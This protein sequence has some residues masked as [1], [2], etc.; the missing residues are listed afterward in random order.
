MVHWSRVLRFNGQSLPYFAWQANG[1]W[2]DS[3]LQHVRDALMNNDQTTQS[4]ATMLFESNVDVIKINELASLLSQPDGEKKLVERFRLASTLKSFNRMLLLSGDEEYEKKQNSFANLHEILNSFMVD[5]CGAADIPMTRLFGQSPGGL[6]ST[7]DGDIRNYYDRINAEQEAD[8]R[9]Q[10]ERLYD[11]LARSTFGTVPENFRF[12]FNPL[13]QISATEQA[14]IDLNH[15]QRDQ[16]YL[17]E[18]VIRQSTVASELREEGTYNNITEDDVK[19]LVKLEEEELNAS[20]E[21]G[22]EVNENGDLV[23]PVEEGEEEVD[24]GTES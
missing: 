17:T 14:T 15:A 24:G 13:W 22:E 9:P 1:R 16:I 19:L 8:L 7:G 11:I 12:E 2:D 3:E 5:V 10:L 6:N 18:G 4:I 21:N 20:K 23:V